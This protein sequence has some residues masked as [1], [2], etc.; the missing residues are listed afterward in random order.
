MPV[1]CCA[2]GCENRKNPRSSK[3]DTDQNKVAF[4]RIP[5]DPNTRRLWLAAINRKDFHPSQ[6]TRLCSKHFI[7]GKWNI[8]ILILHLFLVHTLNLNYI[9]ILHNWNNIYIRGT[10]QHFFLKW[11]KCIE[12][13]KLLFFINL[14]Y[15]KITF[16][17]ENPVLIC[18]AAHF[19]RAGS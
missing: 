16:K 1:S 13:T 18:Q 7:S 8:L 2:I 3:E 5:A 10:Q 11:P 4:Y 19:V 15:K 17:I 14:K 9:I 6:Y 12:M